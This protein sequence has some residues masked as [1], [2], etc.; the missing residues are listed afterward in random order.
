MPTRWNITDDEAKSEIEKLI[1]VM[2]GVH[3]ADK[4]AE[5]RDMLG[6]V[7]RGG[8]DGLTWAEAEKKIT[9]LLKSD[10]GGRSARRAELALRTT[11]FRAKATQKYRKLMKQREIFPWWEYRSRDDGRV[12]ASHAALNGKILPAGHE[13]WQRIFPPWAWGCRC[14]VIPRR[15]YDA[16]KMMQDDEG[17]AHQ[18]QR[19]WDQ[20]MA[21]TIHKH[22]RLPG[23][24]SLTTEDTYRS[25]A[26]SGME[27]WTEEELKS[28]YADHPVIQK[29]FNLYVKSMPKILKSL[30][31]TDLKSSKSKPK[32]KPSDK[33][34]K[35]K[36]GKK[37]KKH[38]KKYPAVGDALAANRNQ[39]SL[40]EEVSEIIDEVHG[41]GTLPKIPVDGKTN[42]VRSLGEFMR[43][44]A[45]GKAM[46]IGVRQKGNHKELTLIHEI[47][48]FIDFSGFQDKRFKKNVLKKFGSERGKGAFRVWLDAVEASPTFKNIPNVKSGYWLRRRELF[49][50]CYA[51]WIA[52][53]SGHKLL[54][55]QVEAIL[56]SPAPW[57]QWPAKEFEPIADAMDAIFKS[58]NWLR[59]KQ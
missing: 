10:L 13:I 54:Q 57:Q 22:L 27:L 44:L 56:K 33:T 19:V 43:D 17:K 24:E 31:L 6:D 1:F 32:T 47:G 3:S 26:E 23:G 11:I 41:D 49:A 51:Q 2:A 9:K 53:R 29:R 15:A 42:D 48:H 7:A 46:R 18:D 5:I 39:K 45:T 35:I 36:D 16:E 50:R 12:R 34:D 30:D 21:D 38:R 4:L 37:Q 58:K 52:T 8:R 55:E 25:P 59:P 20:D 40:V 28:R 14:T